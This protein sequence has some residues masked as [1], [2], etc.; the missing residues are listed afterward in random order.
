MIWIFIIP[1]AFL[2]VGIADMPSGYYTFLRIVVCI[3]SVVIAFGSYSLEE[4]INFGVTLFAVISLLFNPFIPVYLHD[5]EAWSVIDA[6]TGVIYVG[7]G[8]Y[9]VIQGKR[10]E[11]EH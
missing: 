9:A 1:A 3:S 6:V 4:K 7:V 11:N 5:K 10:K 8:I 2:L